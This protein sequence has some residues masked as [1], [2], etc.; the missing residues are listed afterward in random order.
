MRANAAADD[1]DRLP[2]EEVIAQMSSVP[3]R[4]VLCRDRTL[5]SLSMFIMAGL[6][7]TSNALS[8]ILTVLAHHPEHQQKLREE[9]LEAR[10]A[11]GLS[12]DELG[13]L[14][15]LD[16]TIRETLRL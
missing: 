9:L 4:Y 6:D 3:S 13:R 14:P 12:Y 2:E 10:A 15:V 1:K 5:T 11:D 16:A 7:T 8:R